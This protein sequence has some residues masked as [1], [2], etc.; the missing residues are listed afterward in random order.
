MPLADFKA[1]H[2][3][4]YH[5]CQVDSRPGYHVHTYFGQC[6]LRDRHRQATSRRGRRWEN[7]RFAPHSGAVA[8]INMASGQ[9]LCAEPNHHSIRLVA[10]RPKPPKEWERFVVTRA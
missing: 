2:V 7:F 5:I 10:D 4:R 3:S 1:R 8:S 9:Y 6:D